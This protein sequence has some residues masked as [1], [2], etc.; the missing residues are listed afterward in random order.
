MRR[1]PDVARVHA[2]LLRRLAAERPEAR[3]VVL[4]A[5]PGL[6]DLLCA[7][8]ALRA[9]RAA[10]PR[11]H[12]TLVG[13]ESNRETVRRFPR[14]VDRFEAAPGYPGLPEQPVD[15]EA[16]ER[17]VAAVR[18]RRPDLALQLHGSGEVSNGFVLR[19]GAR[20]AG[21]SYPSGAP[22]PG[23]D[24]IPYA[25][26]SEI[27]RVLAPVLALGAPPSGDALEF[28]LRA[29]DEQQRLGL[30]RAWGLP[31]RGYVCVQPGASL[32]E[33]RWG[34]S[35]FAAAAD[36]LAGAGRRVVITGSAAEM[37]LTA[38]VRRAMRSPAVDLGGRTSIGGLAALFAAADLVLCNDS[39]ASH[40]A[41]A[42]RTPSVI[43]F[44]PGADVV[45]WAP[46]DGARHVALGGVRGPRPSGRGHEEAQDVVPVH[47]VVDAAGRQL[48]RRLGRGVT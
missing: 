2:P 21:G 23:E 43:V 7:V 22:S 46:L 45:R 28:P 44:A 8:P 16:L 35:R 13:L 4:R 48:R 47:E 11:A 24:F 27:H 6:G 39:G 15:G 9:L 19:L 41:A 1:A 29:G 38:A 31:E 12:V 25:G 3:I 32:P 40:V 34:A 36:A 37:E 20:H 17:F 18:S 42:V 5:L 14:L 30:L 33:R 26:G 10:L